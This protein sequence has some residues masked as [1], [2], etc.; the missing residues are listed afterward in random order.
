MECVQLFTDT[1]T[2]S[3]HLQLNTF[4][5]FTLHCKFSLCLQNIYRDIFC[6]LLFFCDPLC[7]TS[8]KPE[9]LFLGLV[10]KVVSELYLDS[11]FS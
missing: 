9:T 11:E 10:L 8:L 7:N 3:D 2:L 6:D 4:Q 5:N 1:S